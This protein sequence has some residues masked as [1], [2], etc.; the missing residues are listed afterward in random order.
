[1][2]K[3]ELTSLGITEETAAKVLSLHESELTAEKDKTASAQKEL[4]ASKATV[5]DIT[6]KLKAYDG[7]DVE[8][9]KTDAAAWEKKYN[10]DMSAARIDSALDLALTKA[11]AR[12]AAL[13][14]H[15]IDR[16]IIKEDGGKLIGLSEQLDKIK[17]EKAWLFGEDKIP[18]KELPD[19]STGMKHGEPPSK[20]APATLAAAL[21]EKYK[22]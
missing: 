18:E 16:S 12:D 20:A 6:E 10:E 8:K 9:L 7:V 1:M 2:K 17:S 11:G 21:E 19:A 3:E 14:K 4:E 15:L 13:A 5:R 22:A